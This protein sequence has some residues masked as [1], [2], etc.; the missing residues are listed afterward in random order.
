MNNN[1]LEQIEKETAEA[2]NLSESIIEA[3]IKHKWKSINEATY[4]YSTIED[5]GLGK[6]YVRK[7]AVIKRL[8][9]VERILHASEEELLKEDLSDKKR[10][11]HLD[12]IR[13]VSAEKEYLLTKI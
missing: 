2:L 13:D 6:F 5:A 11:R 7:K 1:I 4:L 10:K 12:I 3:I 8:E 9:K